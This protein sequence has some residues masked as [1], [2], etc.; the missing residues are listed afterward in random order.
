MREQIEAA[1]RAAGYRPPI[2]CTPEE[3]LEDDDHD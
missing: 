2:I 1:C 3:L